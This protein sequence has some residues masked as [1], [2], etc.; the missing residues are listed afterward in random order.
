MI[1]IKVIYHILHVFNGYG[2][3][4]Y[5]GMSS[6]KAM[7]FQLLTGFMGSIFCFI[8]LHFQSNAIEQFW[9]DHLCLPIIAGIL[10]YI[11]SAHVIPEVIETNF[12]IKGTISKVGAFT[13]SVSII[14]YLNKQI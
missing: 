1:V 11:C 5:S 12:G 10:V 14:F 2:I 6:S 13:V 4:M 8:G 9:I 7:R 3:L